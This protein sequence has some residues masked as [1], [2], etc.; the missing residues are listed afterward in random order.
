MD[1]LANRPEIGI[2]GTMGGL[3]GSI[4]STTPVLQFLSALFGVVIGVATIISMTYKFIKW[5]K[6]A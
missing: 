6:E 3:M 1:T 5:I 2:G 4:I